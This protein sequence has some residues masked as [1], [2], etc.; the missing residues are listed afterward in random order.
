M[1]IYTLSQFKNYAKS[2]MMFNIYCLATVQKHCLKDRQELKAHVLMTFMYDNITKS[3][4]Y[5]KQ[6]L[7]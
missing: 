6:H 3:V 1:Y 5:N 4:V 7:K 2:V